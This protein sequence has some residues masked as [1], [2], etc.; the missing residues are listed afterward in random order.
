MISA[1]VVSFI[2][3]FLLLLTMTAT[4]PWSEKVVVVTIFG[5]CLVSGIN[6]I[7]LLRGQKEDV[8]LD[9]DKIIRGGVACPLEA[10]TRVQRGGGPLRRIHWLVLTFDFPSDSVT[11]AYLPNGEDCNR[12]IERLA[13]IRRLSRHD[14]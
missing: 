13:E 6:E 4:L 5:I 9:G 14:S 11:F 10:L 8:Y 3:F 12:R 1:L 7:R 2:G